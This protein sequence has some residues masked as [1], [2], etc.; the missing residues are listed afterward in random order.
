[1]QFLAH[2]L[3]LHHPSQTTCDHLSL[4]VVRERL[5]ID[6]DCIAHSMHVYYSAIHDYCFD[7]SYCNDRKGIY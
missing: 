2:L 1:M 7:Q 3:S 5:V 6:N 4:V